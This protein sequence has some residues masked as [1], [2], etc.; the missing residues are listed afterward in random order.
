MSLG[1]K[2]TFVCSL[3]SVFDLARRATASLYLL[4]PGESGGQSASSRS[5]LSEHLDLSQFAAG[6]HAAWEHA[7]FSFARRLASVTLSPCWMPLASATPLPP[8]MAPE[9]KRATI[10][11]EVKRIIM[12]MVFRGA[13]FVFRAFVGNLNCGL[14]NATAQEKS[15]KCLKVSWALIGLS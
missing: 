3:Q 10:T 15:M 4:P 12:E 2:K 7:A 11:A 6:G 14:V 9:A 5:R 8:A 13:V 1:K